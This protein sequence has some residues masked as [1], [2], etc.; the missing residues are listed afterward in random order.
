M[1]ERRFLIMVEEIGTEIEGRTWVK[2]ADL[3]FHTQQ[4]L[5]DVNQ[6]L[7]TIRDGLIAAGKTY[8][9]A[10]VNTINTGAT[11]RVSLADL[12]RALRDHGF[13]DG[14]TVANICREMEYL[15]L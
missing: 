4:Q 13:S 12:Y 5:K 11:I 3:A 9:I 15:E 6:V 10:E 7:K 2:F 14:D 1:N 8:T